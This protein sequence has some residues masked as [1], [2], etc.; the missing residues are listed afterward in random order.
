MDQ[1]QASSSSGGLLQDVLK[2][3][4]TIWNISFYYISSVKGLEKGVREFIIYSGATYCRD[5]QGN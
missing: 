4:K 5:W 2:W 3:P 1:I